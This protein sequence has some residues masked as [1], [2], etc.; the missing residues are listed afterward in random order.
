[1]KN[2]EIEKMINESAKRILSSFSAYLTWKWMEQFKSEEKYGA[3]EAVKNVEILNKFGSFFQ[4]SIK[5][6]F[7]VFLIDICIFFDNDKYGRALN[8]EKIIE[9]I[10]L[11]DEDRRKVDIILNSKKDFIKKLKKIRNKDIAHYE[12]NFNRPESHVLLY[13]EVEDL[14]NSIQEIFKILTVN[15]NSSVW[16]WKHLVSV[17]DNNMKFLFENLEIGIEERNN[18]IKTKYNINH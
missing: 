4:M 16:T 15:Y 8:L 9:N 5:G 11:K 18:R 1:M 6:T 2:E 3:L 10:E 17:V 14:F 12:I 7:Y 13:K